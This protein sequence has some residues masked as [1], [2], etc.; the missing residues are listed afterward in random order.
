[1]E[2]CSDVSVFL[3]TGGLLTVVQ[4]EIINFC[5][6]LYSRTCSGDWMAAWQGRGLLVSDTLFH[7]S[8]PFVNASHS[9]YWHKSLCWMLCAT[10]NLHFGS[11]LLLHKVGSLPGGEK[12]R[13]RSAEKLKTLFVQITAASQGIQ[14]KR[15]SQSSSTGAIIL[16]WLV[17]TWNDSKANPLSPQSSHWIRW[18]WICWPDSKNLPN[19]MFECGSL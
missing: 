15:A 14:I 3:R 11:P 5:L 1:M 4:T 2:M 10:H 17:I 13:N 19:L 7:P 18:A 8:D 16:M 9:S 12:A 6:L